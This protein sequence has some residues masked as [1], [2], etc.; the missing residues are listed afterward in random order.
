MFGCAPQSGRIPAKLPISKR[1]DVA[2]SPGGV[3]KSGNLR[4]RVA[5]KMRGRMGFAQKLMFGKSRTPQLRP[6]ANLQY[7]GAASGLRLLNGELREV[8]HRRISVL[9]AASGRSA[10][11]CGRPSGIYGGDAC[12]D[13]AGATFLRAGRNTRLSTTPPRRC[14]PAM[15]TIAISEL[16]PRFVARLWPKFSS[17]ED[18]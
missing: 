8:A 11:V 12:F 18:M 4:P 5:A 14:H 16:Q 3:A 13:L 2:K 9:R 6:I 1:E 17:Y 10:M 7:S 15:S